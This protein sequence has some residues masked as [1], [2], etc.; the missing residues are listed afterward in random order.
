[1]LAGTR[2]PGRGHLCPVLLPRFGRPPRVRHSYVVN[3]PPSAAGRSPARKSKFR[4]AQ[5]GISSSSEPPWPTSQGE[6]GRDDAASL[7]EREPPGARVGGG[8]RLLRESPPC[9]D[10]SSPSPSRP[11]SMVNSP[12]NGRRTTSVEY[13]SA[14]DWSVYFRV[15]S[16]PSR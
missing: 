6:L 12:R 8:G 14:P 7:I 13:F 3:Q 2:S 9:T 1:M 4:T 5:N 10:L 16:V 15:S 11:P